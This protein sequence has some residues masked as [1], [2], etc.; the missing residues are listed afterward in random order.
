MASL[1]EA[2]LFG[3]AAPIQSSAQRTDWEASPHTGLPPSCDTCARSGGF[4]GGRAPR[5]IAS[6]SRCGGCFV[7]LYC[8]RACQIKAWKK[9][10]TVCA[11]SCV[12]LSKK[13]AAVLE[14]SE[15]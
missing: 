11:A 1:M 3:K 12:A 8:S 7:A 15:L 5:N 6:L 13:R 10:K 14:Q 2:A 4:F 9:H